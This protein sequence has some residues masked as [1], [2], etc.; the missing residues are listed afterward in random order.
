MT[1]VVKQTAHNAT[2]LRKQC[3]I[4]KLVI[5]KS[6]PDQAQVVAR[7]NREQV[8]QVAAMAKAL[9]TVYFMILEDLCI[10][11]CRVIVSLFGKE[12]LC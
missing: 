8:Q 1:P 10:V 3:A 9:K 7:N 11:M 2:H 5:W 6:F 4:L 12:G